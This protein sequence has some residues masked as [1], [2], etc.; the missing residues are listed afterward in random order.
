MSFRPEFSLKLKLFDIEK[1]SCESEQKVWRELRFSSILDFEFLVFS[2]ERH[3]LNLHKV[4]LILSRFVSYLL[5]IH[6]LWAPSNFEHT[7]FR[8]VISVVSNGRC[9]DSFETS[10]RVF[11]SR[12]FNNVEMFN[13]SSELKNFVCQSRTGWKEVQKNIKREYK[14]VWR[15]NFQRKCEMKFPDFSRL[16]FIF[17]L[18]K[19]LSQ[20]RRCKLMDSSMNFS[21][22]FSVDSR[23]GY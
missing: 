8:R 15:G 2:I 13:L 23:R 1:G 12:L 10:T 4:L 14:G 3:T 16:T 6:F 21:L 9:S 7:Q 20:Q 22:D 18:L 11:R 17:F 19:K 5:P